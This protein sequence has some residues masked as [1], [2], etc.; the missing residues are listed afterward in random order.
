GGSGGGGGG[1]QS[2]VGCFVMTPGSVGTETTATPSSAGVPPSSRRGREHSSGGDGGGGGCRL[3]RAPFP[4]GGSS[5]GSAGSGCGG[6]ATPHAA[7]ALHGGGGSGGG[8]EFAAT[9]LSFRRAAGCFSYPAASERVS[10]SSWTLTAEASSVRG[11]R[12]VVDGAYGAEEGRG[13]AGSGSSAMAPRNTQVVP[14]VRGCTPPVRVAESR[15][16]TGAV[17]SSPRNGV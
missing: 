17:S 11:S 7:P 10:S 12:E 9:A 1:E 15:A 8:N 5:A 4:S 13:K 2:V 16:T 14:D 3:D 6:D